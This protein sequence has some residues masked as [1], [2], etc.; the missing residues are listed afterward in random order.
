MAGPIGAEEFLRDRY[1][2]RA[3]DVAPLPKGFWSSAHS[4]RL[5]GRDL[6]LRIG[7][8][9]DAF[10]KERQAGAFASASLPVPEVLEIGSVGDGRSYAVSVL[11]RGRFLEQLD[12]TSAPWL[13]PAVWRMLDALR[14]VPV[15]PGAGAGWAADWG[16]QASGSWNDA[17]TA[18][19]PPFGRRADGWEGRL[20]ACPQIAD[21]VQGCR[22]SMRSIIRRGACPEI[23]HVVHGDLLYRN[24]LVDEEAQAITA[25]LDWGQMAY[26]DFVFDLAWLAFFAPRYPAVASLDIPGSA[27]RHYA[28]IGLDVPELA[29]R[30]HCY[31]IKIGLDRLLAYVA[32]PQWPFPGGAVTGTAPADFTVTADR[33]AGLLAAGPGGS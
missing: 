28:A 11:H 32:G 21:L 4:F 5:D 25:V 27:A 20:E 16:R 3:R 15:S 29:A 19:W 9:R 2:G 12:E 24:V 23:R 1:G 18:P 14:L 8:R 26:G 33:L 30:L 13:A 22:E 7:R 31:E 17:L 10:E 6:V